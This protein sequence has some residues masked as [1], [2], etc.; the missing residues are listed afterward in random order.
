MLWSTLV[1]E[2]SD[3]CLLHY[4]SRTLVYILQPELVPSLQKK[5]KDFDLC[6][7]RKRKR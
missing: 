3:M 2:S 1:F 6:T 4:L 7:A 5:E